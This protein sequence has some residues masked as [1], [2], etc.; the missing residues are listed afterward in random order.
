[1]PF[2]LKDTLTGKYYR[3]SAAWYEGEGTRLVEIT[4]AKQIKRAG[5]MRNHF[6]NRLGQAEEYILDADDG[7]YVPEDP[8]DQATLDFWTARRYLQDYGFEIVEVKNSVEET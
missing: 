7:D 5:I 3:D 8:F 2:I 1:M 4:D 6:E